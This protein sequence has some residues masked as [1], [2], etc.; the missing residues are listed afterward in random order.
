VAAGELGLVLLCLIRV[1]DSWPYCSLWQATQ[2]AACQCGSEEASTNHDLTGVKIA[3]LVGNGFQ[4]D[5][6]LDAQ[7]FFRRA[8]ATVAMVSPEMNKGPGAGKSGKP[9]V[10][11][12]IDRIN[13]TGF[14]ALLLPGERASADNLSR[15]SAAVALVRSFLAA[16]KPIGAVADGAKILVAADGIAGLQIAAN[17][18]LRPAI[19]NA[20]AIWSEKPVVYDRYLVTASHIQAIEPFCDAFAENCIDHKGG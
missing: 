9:P 11:I 13:E 20:G 6:L 17:P 16:S 4:E 12:A 2:L 8:G 7:E 19:E 14:D 1:N 18:A 5:P 10:N 3:I 15:N